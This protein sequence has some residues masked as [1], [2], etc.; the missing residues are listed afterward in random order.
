[1]DRRDF[2]KKS[3]TLAAA[4]AVTACAPNEGAP[5]AG[6]APAG[7]DEKGPMLQNYPGVGV[8]GYGC[9]RW[10]MTKDGDGNDVIDQ[11]TV[12]AL[13]DEALAHG[14]NYFDTSPV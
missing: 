4:A 2:L 7:T 11:E 5:A 12:N 6:S 3:G 8:L 14:V 1:M 13:V 9:M 10:P